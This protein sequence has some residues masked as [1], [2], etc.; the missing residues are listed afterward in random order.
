MDYLGFTE[1]ERFVKRAEKLLGAEMISEW[2]LYL[3]KFPEDGVIIPASSGIRKLRWAASGRG[4]RGGA[5]VIYYFANSAGRVFLLD[6]Y[7][8]NEQENLSA[9]DIKDLKEAVEFWLNELKKL[10]ELW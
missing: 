4:K 8:K 5:R 3:C 2:Q 1:T 7:A 9:E 6:I 10:G